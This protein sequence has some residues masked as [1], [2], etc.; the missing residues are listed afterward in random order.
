MAKTAAPKNTPN[1]RLAPV[2]PPSRPSKQLDVFANPNAR[3]DYVIQFQ[4]PE[5]TCNCPLTGQPDFAHLSIDMV[6]DQLCVELKSLK[7]YMWSYR[8][9]GAFH[10][11]VSNDILDD[12]VKATRPRF[13]RITARWYVRGGIYTNVVA[14]HCKKGW[15]PQPMVLLPEH[16]TATGLMR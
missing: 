7:M 12:I 1:Q 5:F 14:E 9:E 13:V 10:E 11:K 8:N 15:K 6:A 16:P 3:R 2:T 4:I